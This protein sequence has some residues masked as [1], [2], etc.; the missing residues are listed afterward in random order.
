MSIGKKALWS[1]CISE[2]GTAVFPS[3]PHLKGFL[4]STFLSFFLFLGGTTPMGRSSDLRGKA[5]S[6]THCARP[7]IKPG[8]EPVSQGS[9]DATDPVTPQQELLTGLLF[10]QQS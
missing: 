1:P 4:L 2:I 10:S 5:G 8:S 6:L 9:R 3:R 7:E